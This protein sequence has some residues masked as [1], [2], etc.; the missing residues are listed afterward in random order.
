MS[1]TKEHS[2]IPRESLCPHHTVF[3]TI[4]A[5]SLTT[6]LKDAQVVGAKIIRGS[7]MFLEQGVAQFELHTGVK[8]PR[9][10]MEN[11]ISSALST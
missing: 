9:E 6:L 8:A 2:P 5:P 3:E 4:Y 11:I 10:V 7:E 1:D